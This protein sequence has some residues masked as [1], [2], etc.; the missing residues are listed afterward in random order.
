MPTLEESPF[1]FDDKFQRRIL[2]AATKDGTT[3]SENSSL[4]NPKLYSDEVLSTIA[5]LILEFYKRERHAP[6][7]AAL[8]EECKRVVAPG[9]TFEEY[10]NTVRKL[11]RLR[12]SND[13]YFL[14]KAKEFIRH[15]TVLRAMSEASLNVSTGNVDDA[16]KTLRRAFES[17]GRTDVAVDYVSSMDGRFA[18]YAQHVDGRDPARLTT[19]IGPLDDITQGGI[20]AGE[21]AL[22]VAPPKRGKSTMLVNIGAAAAL[23]GHGVYHVTLELKGKVVAQKYDSRFLELPA[24]DLYRMPEDARQILDGLRS[25]LKARIQ[26]DERPMRSLSVDAL[27]STVA[28]SKNVKLV[29]VDYADLLKAGGKREDRRIELAETYESLRGMASELGV[30]VWTASQAN[31]ESVGAGVIGMDGVAECFDKVAIADFAFSLCQTVKESQDGTMRLF[32]MA[33]RLGQSNDQVECSVDWER[34]LIKAVIDDIDS[35]DTDEAR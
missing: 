29:I 28:K 3:I 11:R 21:L 13:S 8:M 30:A 32:V 18:S 26:I 34:S 24:R 20:N 2:A 9:R 23:A 17:N 33:N 35:S 12:G 5:S 22:V 14:S 7:T 4:L 27:S 19:G 10:V 6:V 31:R 25:K 16:W 15:Q 1:S